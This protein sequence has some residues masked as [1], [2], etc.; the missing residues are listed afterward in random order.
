MADCRR[1]GGDAYAQLCAMSYRQAIGGHKLAA[2][3]STSGT[4][5]EAVESLRAALG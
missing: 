4:I 5:D 1:A 2:G 3:Y